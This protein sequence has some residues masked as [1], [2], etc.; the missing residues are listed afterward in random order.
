MKTGLQ[1]VALLALAIGCG[2][3]A[4]EVPA[5]PALPR[6]RDVGAILAD[7][8]SDRAAFEAAIAAVPPGGEAVIAVP[9]IGRPY[10]LPGTWLD[11]G[12]RHITWSVDPGVTIN[13]GAPVEWLRLNGPVT[14]GRGLLASGFGNRDDNTGFR[15]LV[16]GGGVFAHPDAKISGYA[17]VEE[18]AFSHE[19]GRAGLYMSVSDAGQIGVEGAGIAAHDEITLPKGAVAANALRVGM[20]VDAPGTTFPTIEGAPWR[21]T[22]RITGWKAEGAYATA[23]EIDGWYRSNPKGNGAVRETPSVDRKAR[24]GRILVNP[25][26]KIWGSNLNLYLNEEDAPR[27]EQT[28]G[29]FAEWAVFNDTG[30]DFAPDF[31][32]NTHP[33]HFYGVDLAS[34]GENGGGTAFQVRGRQA[35]DY[36]FRVKS[37]RT[38]FQVDGTRLTEGGTGFA[39]TE[40][41]AGGPAVAFAARTSDGK[42]TDSYA[43]IS[44]KAPELHLGRAT[45]PSRPSLVLHS[46]GAGSAWDA[47]LFAEGGGKG[48]GQATLTIQAGGLVVD[49]GGGVVVLR[50]LPSSADGLPAGALYRD[51]AGFVKIVP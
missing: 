43:E 6:D 18:Q 28:S 47:R 36:G 15:I 38:G 49:A 32:Q 22:T 12:D 44:G 10:R 3:A 13:D 9:D 51:G 50:N 21:Y 39:T 4:A 25:L 5:G 20:F 7:V 19:R 23:L 33:L 1:V 17:T 46:G 45:A 48:D 11:P 8:P 35:W 37:G 31:Q 40:T 14:T 2:S 26:N 30:A 24:T 41:A 27:Y 29:A 34:N 16:G 42:R